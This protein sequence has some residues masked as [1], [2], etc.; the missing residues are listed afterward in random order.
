MAKPAKMLR[1]LL[2]SLAKKPATVR[3][4]AEGKEMPKGFR[5]KLNF[6]PEKCIGCKMCARLPYRRYRDKKN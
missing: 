3:Y 2:K 5:G 1:E 6:Y 4:P